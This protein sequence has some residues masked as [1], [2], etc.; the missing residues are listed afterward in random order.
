MV[1]KSLISKIFAAIK[2]T[3]SEIS[4]YEDMFAV[5]RDIESDN[6]ELAHKFN[7][8]GQLSVYVKGAGVDSVVEMAITVA[9]S[10]KITKASA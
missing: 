2:K 9:A 7:F 1:N 10:T 6:F 8:K 5:C 4:A 3:P